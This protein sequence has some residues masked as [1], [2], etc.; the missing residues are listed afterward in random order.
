MELFIKYAVISP[1]GPWDVPLTVVWPLFPNFPLYSF[2][3]TFYPFT[4]H[5]SEPRHTLWGL[6]QTRTEA[7]LS[8]I[9][10]HGAL[11]G[12]CTTDEK[13]ITERA[14]PPGMI[15]L[16]IP[17]TWVSLFAYLCVPW[18]LLL[19]TLLYSCTWIS[20]FPRVSVWLCTYMYGLPGWLP[21]GFVREA[22]PLPTLP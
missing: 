18:W 2:M 16:W 11:S 19:P 6:N 22:N 9:S 5:F 15:L 20:W 7:F 10:W 17:C 3:A 4:I 12:L 1:Q 21:G 14:F 8:S 13:E